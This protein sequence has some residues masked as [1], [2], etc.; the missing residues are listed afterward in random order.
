MG[1]AW[2]KETNP[3]RTVTNQGTLS[4]GPHLSKPQFSHLNYRDNDIYLIV[5][6]EHEIRHYAQNASCSGS[7][8]CAPHK[9]QS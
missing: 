8:E 3:L 4:S 2:V 7:T 9:G 6:S 5:Y 1:K